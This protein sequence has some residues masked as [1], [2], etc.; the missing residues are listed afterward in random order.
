MRIQFSLKWLLSYVVICSCVLG[1]FTRWAHKA[2]VQQ[3][4]VEYII[5]HGGHNLPWI[6][7]RYD[8]EP[9]GGWTDSG[10][11][12]SDDFFHDVVAVSL[13]D[14]IEGTDDIMKEVAHLERVEALDFENTDL[15]D[16]GLQE[17][18]HLKR[19]RQLH[20]HEAPLTDASLELLSGLPETV[21]VDVTLTNISDGALARLK[22]ARGDRMGNR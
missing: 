19:L 18:R 12:W 7:I 14:C 1:V 9:Q 2:I 11:P 16:V 10:R 8:H 21:T 4:A 13:L 3:R 15:S 20:I 5:S 6:G 22:R 17:I